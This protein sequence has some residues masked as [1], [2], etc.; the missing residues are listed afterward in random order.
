MSVIPDIPPRLV[1]QAQGRRCIAFV[2]TGLSAAAG[3]P[4][5]SVLIEKFIDFAVSERKVTP[6]DRQALIDAVASRGPEIVAGALKNVVGMGRFHSFLERELKGLSPQS[7]HSAII[8][9]P[10]LFR[11]VFTTNYDRLIEKAFASAY[12]DDDLCVATPEEIVLAR[13][14]DERNEFYLLKLHGCISRDNQ[15]LTRPEFIDLELNQAY[16]DFVLAQFM[17]NSLL[18]MGHSLSD[19]DTKRCL[20][21]LGRGASPSDV[22]HYCLI[23]RRDIHPLVQDSMSTLYGVEFI[24]YDDHED[25]VPF[26]KELTRLVYAEKLSDTLRLLIPALGWILKK[27]EIVDGEQVLLC[28]RLE[29]SNTSTIALA[30]V[31][32]DATDQMIAKAH[33]AAAQ[34][35]QDKTE[36][37]KV[38]WELK[39]SRK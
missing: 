37:I 26:L 39:D 18:F 24:E 8:N 33:A 23:R 31:P 3:A 38:P 29:G 17:C 15:V 4:S 28:K 25:V 16:G 1:E 21:R 35:H 14:A 6:K 27:T 13:R 7:V 32:Y 36:V 9:P 5:W 20:E 34:C 22:R 12:P 11:A 30:A 10:H 19:D 2:G